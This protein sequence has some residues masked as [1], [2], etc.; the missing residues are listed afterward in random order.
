MRT[1]KPTKDFLIRRMKN[2]SMNAKIIQDALAEYPALTEKSIAREMDV[3][4][5]CKHIIALSDP[6]LCR[7]DKDA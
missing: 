2:V 4:A 7:I 6:C 5:T 3:L 1:P